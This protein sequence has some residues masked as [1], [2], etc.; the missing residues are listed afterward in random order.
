MSAAGGA[1]VPAA[2]SA[3][4][5]A[6][7]TAAKLSAEELDEKRVEH[8]AGALYSRL[9]TQDG[10]WNFPLLGELVENVLSDGPTE[11]SIRFVLK[12]LH[13]I[14]LI[15]RTTR[16]GPLPAG[17]WA[18]EV[19]LAW[20]ETH[21]LDPTLNEVLKCLLSILIEAANDRWVRPK[22]SILEFIASLMTSLDIKLAVF[23]VQLTS[24]CW[25]G[26]VSQYMREVPPYDP[27]AAMEAASADR[28]KHYEPGHIT[29]HD[30]PEQY[31][32]V[33]NTVVPAHRAMVVHR[34]YGNGPKPT[35]EFL[36]QSYYRRHCPRY[37]WGGWDCHGVQAETDKVRTLVLMGL[38]RPDVRLRY[39]TLYVWY[40]HLIY[41]INATRVEKVE[42]PTKELQSDYANLAAI[43]KPVHD[44]SLKYHTQLASS[45][46]AAN[47]STVPAVHDEDTLV[48]NTKHAHAFIEALRETLLQMLMLP[49]D[50]PFIFG[51]CKSN[52]KSKNESDVAV[53]IA[54]K[55][56]NACKESNPIINGFQIDREWL[57]GFIYWI[58]LV[59]SPGVGLVPSDYWLLIAQLA[60][61]HDLFF[62]DE[63]AALVDAGVAI[64]LIAP[65]RETSEEVLELRFT[66]HTTEIV[67]AFG[68]VYEPLEKWVAK[69]V[70]LPLGE[71]DI[72]RAGASAGASARP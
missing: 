41:I 36:E 46:L 5:P 14:D 43:F 16:Q 24:L 34:P 19:C 38:H 18:P 11:V 45:M 50:S 67:A 9:L 6:A 30:V 25:A 64:T 63:L 53:N 1:A 21:S 2:G 56:L 61:V 65:G 3:A 27:K 49:S 37:E 33:T 29:Y 47:S 35:G 44:W 54:L 13:Y 62:T 10:E 66:T 8:E 52:F 51:D 17:P 31:S 22:Q 57:C 72:K 4:V 69:K 60:A 58:P 59:K 68:G 55:V 39:R 12:A 42:L 20:M 70:G 71:G 7:A 40:M 32:P 48:F 23:A 26:W 28:L 15:T